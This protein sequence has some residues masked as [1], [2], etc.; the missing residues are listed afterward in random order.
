VVKATL[1]KT[2]YISPSG[3]ANAAAA[4]PQSGVAPGSIL[5]IFGASL[6][7]S[8]A[9]GP[10]SPMVQAL[11][12][13]TVHAGDRLFPIYFVSPTQ[14]NVQLPDDYAQGDSTLTVSADGLPDVQAQFTVVRDAPGLFQQSVNNLNFAVAL[15]ADGTPVTTAAP[16]IKGEVLTLYGTGFGPADQ[17][18]PM[19][20]AIPAS[21]VYH[22]VDPVTVQAGD[23]AITP[24]SAI[25]VAG[26]V[27]LDAVLFRLPDSVPGASNVSLVVTVNGQ[28]SNTVILPVQ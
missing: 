8:L 19:G 26:K 16:A 20:F 13:V 28:S 2:P 22:I 27:G 5:S 21:P 17:P 3:V 9:T 11:G 18:R 4:T 1:D 23:T 25:A 10:D 7:S 14:V 15:H 12:G 24:D 6:A